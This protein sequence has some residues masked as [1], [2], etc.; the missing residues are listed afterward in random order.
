M[1]KHYILILFFSVSLILACPPVEEPGIQPAAGETSGPL[2][3]VSISP[4]SGSTSVDP[5]SP[6]RIQFSHSLHPSYVGSLSFSE[7]PLTLKETVN[8]TESNASKT[9]ITFATTEHLNDTLVFDPEFLYAYQ[10][11]SGIQL[12]GFK[13][14]QGTD[15]STLD[16][17][18]INFSTDTIPLTNE[19]SDWRDEIIY[20]VLTDRFDDGSSL[21]NSIMTNG[22]DFSSAGDGKK[23]QGGDFQGLIDRLDYLDSLGITALWITAPV[24]Q[25]WSNAGWTSYHG[26]WAQNFLEVDPHLGTMADLREL[27]SEAHSRG[28]KVIMDVVVNHTGSLF[29]YPS[30]TNQWSPDFQ[31]A[32]PYSIQWLDEMGESWPIT[33]NRIKPYFGNI[34]S[35][36][37]SDFFTK[38]GGNATGGG[39]SS[40]EVLEGDF[41]GLRDIDTTNANVRAALKHIFQWWIAN[42]NI[43]GFRI[44]TVKHVE[45]AFWQDFIPAIRNFALTEGGKD[46]YMVAEV[47]DGNPSNLGEFTHSGMLD[48]VL[49]FNYANGAVF[50]WNGNI[51]ETTV[52]VGD[53]ASRKRTNTLE[54]ILNTTR[55]VA[56]LTTQSDH[57]SDGVQAADLIGHFIDNHDIYRFLNEGNS[58]SGLANAAPT[59][60]EIASLQ[61]ALAWLLTWEGIPVIY[62]GTEQNYKQTLGKDSNGEM[63]EGNGN[64]NKSNRPN[65]WQISHSANSNQVF[66]TTNST[67]ALISGLSQLRMTYPALRRGQVAIRWSDNDG[68]GEDA[69]IIAYLRQGTTDTEDILVVINTHPTEAKS[70]YFNSGNFVD[71]DWNSSTLSVIPIPGVAGTGT[72][73]TDSVSTGTNYTNEVS[74]V[75]TNGTGQVNFQIPA[76]S[77]RLLKLSSYT[78]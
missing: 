28:I 22:D 19:V 17:S 8:V 4:S 49:G 34:G 77:V 45:N 13:N 6:I 25:A 21:N 60:A 73:W 72:V 11:Y 42:T 7:P 51:D 5:Y 40:A 32:G 39:I 66:N 65:L 31:D 63:G 14:A 36:P 29:K 44:D 58:S 35:T 24:K 57:N 43:D 59:S 78:P 10:D 18:S 71:T 12:Q 38:K 15:L 46:F 1:N 16:L 74:T 76:N 41:D 70:P 68:A 26:Y 9:T 64:V 50:N 30:E 47:Y 3:L 33:E 52:F 48:S 27:V 75:A 55:G 23:Y 56:N 53:F 20:F 54:T 69:G 2:E 61:N 67:F 37:L 62:Y